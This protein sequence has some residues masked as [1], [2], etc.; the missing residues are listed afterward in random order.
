MIFVK[1][2]KFQMGDTFGD[3]SDDERPIHT[4]SINGFLI[5]KYEITNVQFCEFVFLVYI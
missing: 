2:G 4:V 5:S 1:G 3:G